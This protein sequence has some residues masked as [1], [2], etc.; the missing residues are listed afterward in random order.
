[1]L[2]ETD[3]LLL[4]KLADHVAKDSAHGVETLIRLAD[5]REANVIKEDFLDNKDGNSLAELGTRL[6]DTQA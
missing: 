4:H 6:H 1:M 5:I 3:G 2:K